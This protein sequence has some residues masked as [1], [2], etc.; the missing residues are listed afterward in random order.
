MKKVALLNVFLFC[1]GIFCIKSSFAQKANKDGNN[2]LSNN[3]Y[4]FSVMMRDS[5]IKTF[6][7]KIYT[8]VELHRTYLIYQNDS[9]S[10]TDPSREQK[11]YPEQTLEANRVDGSYGTIVG[12]PTDS[13]WLFRVIRGKINAYAKLPE[14]KSLK[15]ESICA[16][17]SG[18]TAILKL[19]ATELGRF[20][21]DDE[22]AYT[23]LKKKNYLAAIQAYNKNIP[24]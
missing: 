2:T 22:E 23:A 17:Q 8:N 12:V 16:F 10:K 18:K 15:A 21:M 19:T 4:E 5:S 20:V 9:L 7:S 13:C 24:Q 11:I 14:K 6:K 1:V 3:T